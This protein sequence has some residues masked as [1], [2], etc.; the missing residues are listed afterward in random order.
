V[1]VWTSIETPLSITCACLPTLPA[2]FKAWQK[3]IVGSRGKATT[4]VSVFRSTRTKNGTAVLASK[5]DFDYIDGR[6]TIPLSQ[7]SGKDIDSVESGLSG[8]YVSQEFTV[9]RSDRRYR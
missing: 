7:K 6:D 3:K 1:G 8:V 5:D 2:Y 4:G 9:E